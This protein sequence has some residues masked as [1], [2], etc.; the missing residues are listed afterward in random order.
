L[1]LLIPWIAA[2]KSRRHSMLK[3]NA[4]LVRASWF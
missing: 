3:I 1:P 2:L 4:R